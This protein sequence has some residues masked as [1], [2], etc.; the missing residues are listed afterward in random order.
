M[1]SMSKSMYIGRLTR[2]PELKKINVRGEE[3]SVV[4]FTIAVDR[5][6]GEGADFY[7]IVAWRG[8][9]DTVKRFMTKG[10]LVYVEGRSQTRSYDVTKENVT[11]Q[12]YVQETH[13]TKVEFLDRAPQGQEAVQDTP[14]AQTAGGG[15][16]DY[17]QQNQGGNGIPW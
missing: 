1:P 14:V 17:G 10:R 8:L 2:D 12:N 5:E 15:Y 6:V 7:N 13:A 16:Q 9:A 3:V 4:N 11:F